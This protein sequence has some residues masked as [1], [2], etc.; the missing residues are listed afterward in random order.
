MTAERLAFRA[1]LSAI[2]YPKSEMECGGK[3]IRTPD[4]QLAKLA[5][6]QLSYAPAPRLRIVD[7]GWRIAIW[8]AHAPS[9]VDAGAPAGMNFVAICFGE[10][11]KPAREARALPKKEN[12]GGRSLALRH[13]L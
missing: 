9:R 1:I 11:P 7:G 3:G 6:Y 4:I 12:A 13:V 2:R 8:G 5:L 10:A